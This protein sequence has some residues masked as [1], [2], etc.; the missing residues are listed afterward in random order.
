MPTSFAFPI[1]AKSV[2]IV[3]LATTVAATFASAQPGSL[4]VLA[5][6]PAKGGICHAIP[7]TASSRKMGIVRTAMF[8]LAVPDRAVSVSVDASGRVIFFTAR[9]GRASTVQKGEGENVLVFFLPD[10][11]VRSGERRYHTSNTVANTSE[12]KKSPL[13]KADT[14]AV[15][16]LAQLVIARCM[17]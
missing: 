14:V 12:E 11:S 6:I 13:A 1:R 7:E 8:D 2:A 16:K 10:G 15:R 17:R 5:P 3:A 9:A 4:P